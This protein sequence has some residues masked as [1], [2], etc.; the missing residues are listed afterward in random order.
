MYKRLPQARV[1]L[2]R[3][4]KNHTGGAQRRQA[5]EHLEALPRGVRRKVIYEDSDKEGVSVPWADVAARHTIVSVD[6]RGS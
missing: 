1:D 5:S 6:G 2:P 3:W 4:H